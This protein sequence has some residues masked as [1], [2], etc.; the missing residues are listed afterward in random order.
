MSSAVTRWSPSCA[1]TDHESGPASSNTNE[2]A[3]V[4]TLTMSPLLDEQTCRL[5]CISL[6]PGQMQEPSS[7]V[8]AAL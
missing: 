3:D 2:M 1:P 8:A 6:K 4:Q 7:R 5:C